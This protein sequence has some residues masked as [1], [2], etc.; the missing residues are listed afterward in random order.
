MTNLYQKGTIPYTALFI[1][2]Q[3]KLFNMFPPKHI[4]VFG[5][6]L[7]LE[8]DPSNFK[9]ISVGKE[10]K[11]KIITRISDNKGDALLVETDRSKKVHPHITLSCAEGIRRSYSDEMIEKAF[12]NNSV[13]YL[14]NSVEIAVVEGYFD[15]E[16]DIVS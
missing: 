16:N 7:T 9:S 13:E 1:I 8:F 2:D 6:H 11:L 5:H 12:E 10:S 3:E 4:H 14:D 15:G